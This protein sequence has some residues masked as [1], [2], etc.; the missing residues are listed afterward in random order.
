MEGIMTRVASTASEACETDD[1]RDTTGMKRSSIGKTNGSLQPISADF[2]HHEV[3]K[4]ILDV[5]TDHDENFY[6]L[7]HEW[8]GSYVARALYWLSLIPTIFPARLHPQS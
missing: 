6:R 3:G 5:L 1:I 4:S 2:G 7:T 8:K